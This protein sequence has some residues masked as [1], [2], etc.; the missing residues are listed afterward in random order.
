MA[1][2]RK[3]SYP[4]ARNAR[5]KGA[6]SGGGAISPPGAVAIDMSAAHGRAG[7]SVGSRVRILGS[8]L[9]AGEVAVVERLVQGVIPAAMVRTSSGFSRQARTIDLEPTVGDAP[10]ADGSEGDSADGSAEIGAQA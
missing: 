2:K 6:P 1:R 7:L 8:G 5:K 3:I 10:S 9:Y 4:P